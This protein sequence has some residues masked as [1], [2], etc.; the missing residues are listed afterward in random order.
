MRTKI[1][2]PLIIALVMSA[3]SSSYFARSGNDDLY[4]TPGK[5]DANRQTASNPQPQADK[6][7]GKISDYEKYRQQVENG[8]QPAVADNNSDTR[9]YNDSLAQANNRDSRE[10]ATETQQYYDN[11]ERNYAVNNAYLDDYSDDYLYSSRIR[12][13]H[14]YGFGGYYDPFY[15]D[16]FWYSPGLSFSLGYGFGYGGYGMGFGY[17]P[18]SYYYSPFYSPYYGYGYGYGGY[19][20]GFY[21]GYYYGNYGYNH[22]GSFYN[23][24]NKYS[25]GNASPYHGVNGRSSSGVY[26]RTYSTTG[27]RAGTANQDYSR[28]RYTRSY[29]TPGTTMENRSVREGTTRDRSTVGSSQSSSVSR[30]YTPSYSKP[31]TYSRPSYNDN[32]SGYSRSATSSAPRSTSSPS[33]SRSSSGS[34]SSYSS[35]S[36]SRSYTPS[37]S[38]SSSH[39]SSS[40]SSSSG[41]SY[42]GGGGGG[43]SHSSGGRR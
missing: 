31:R 38:S 17:S 20:R 29:S 2:V 41:G 40:G 22:Y 19:Y 28:S 33:Y 5:T 15:S 43:G 7:S 36:S 21:D 9:Y 13:F 30:T 16:P 34:G 35:G 8:G 11:N 14:S 3:C 42:S 32:S 6:K 4:Y 23:D 10:P 1:I 24:Y 27:N 18:W 26:N 25:S 37:S 12:R 39:S